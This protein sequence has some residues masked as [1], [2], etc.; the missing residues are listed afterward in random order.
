MLVDRKTWIY[1]KQALDFFS[2]VDNVPF[3]NDYLH[4]KTFFY[5]QLPVLYWKQYTCNIEN[6]TL[7]NIFFL[8]FQ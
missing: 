5:H 3:C 4:T 7:V 8:Y 1:V 6:K 2:D